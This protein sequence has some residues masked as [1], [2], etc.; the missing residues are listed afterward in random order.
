[1]LCVVMLSSSVET[2]FG[3]GVMRT[4]ICFPLATIDHFNCHV[5][6]LDWTHSNCQS[7]ATHYWVICAPATFCE[8][9]VVPFLEPSS[10]Q[11]TTF[12]TLDHN[13][14]KLTRFQFNRL[15]HVYLHQC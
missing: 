13:H 11:A 12:S 2:H 6:G 4:L 3:S 1:M 10:R 5:K 15:V 9:V 14:L 8:V 7:I